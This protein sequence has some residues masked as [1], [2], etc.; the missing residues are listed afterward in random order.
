MASSIGDSPRSRF[1]RCHG[2]DCHRDGQ[3]LRRQTCSRVGSCR[4]VMGWS[5]C[6]R[7]AFPLIRERPPSA[8]HA[9]G[10]WREKILKRTDERSCRVTYLYNTCLYTLY[11]I[12]LLVSSLLHRKRYRA[13]TEML[14]LDAVQADF[15]RRGW[16]TP[17]PQLIHAMRAYLF[18]SASLLSDPTSNEIYHAWETKQDG[19]ADRMRWY[20]KHA[21]TPVF[22]EAC[23]E[24]SIE[25]YCSGASGT[26]CV[27]GV[28]LVCDA[29]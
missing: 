5:W 17:P 25:A 27:D 24:G 15:Q 1:R 18:S 2:S 20:N 29:V 23:F 21:D 22:S 11:L 8:L 4:R 6:A 3:L 19:V 26:W 16:G 10:S 28:S 14:C 9:Q 7:M 12:F 13:R